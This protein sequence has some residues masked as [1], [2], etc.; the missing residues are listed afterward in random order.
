MRMVILTA[1]QAVIL[2]AAFAP[3]PRYRR[4]TVDLFLLER[5][6]EEERAARHEFVYGANDVRLFQATLDTCIERRRTVLAYRAGDAEDADACLRLIRTWAATYA[7]HPRY[8][9]AWAPDA[10]PVARG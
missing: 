4:L 10:S 6:A 2:T 9:P 3:R 5:I 7:H 8:D 1:I